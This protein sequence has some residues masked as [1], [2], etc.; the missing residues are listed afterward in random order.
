MGLRRLAVPDSRYQHFDRRGRVLRSEMSVA[1]RHR[2]GL[3][4]EQFAHRIEIDTAHC[5][6]LANVWRRSWNLKR[7][8]TAA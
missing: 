2:N 7:L 6:L 4:A 1:K 3:V 5:R 8:T